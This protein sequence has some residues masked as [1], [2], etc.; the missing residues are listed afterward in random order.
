M[1]IV[2]VTLFIKAADSDAPAAVLIPAKGFHVT[3]LHS[4][5]GC[6]DLYIILN[7]LEGDFQ[8]FSIEN[9]ALYDLTDQFVFSMIINIVKMVKQVADRLIDLIDSVCILD[10][11]CFFDLGITKSSFRYL[12]LMVQFFNLPDNVFGGTGSHCLGKGIGEVHD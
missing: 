5:D 12:L 3:G 11:L 1:C 10:P 4:D 2:V 7:D 6:T 9:T 8:I